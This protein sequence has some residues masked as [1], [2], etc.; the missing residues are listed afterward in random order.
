VPAE[1]TLDTRLVR[2]IRGG[3]DALP[4]DI[5]C[6]RGYL[7]MITSLLA[8]KAAELEPSWEQACAIADEIETLQS[9]EVAV[10]ERAISIE[11]DTLEAVL[12]KLA[13]WRS[14]SPGTED[15]DLGSHRNRLILSVEA[16]VDRML[17]RRPC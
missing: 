4:N 11:A 10:A 17:G 6:L 13:I 1:S 9:L 14:L 16:D 15:E 7:R 5:T 8:E 3:A 2:A 12:G